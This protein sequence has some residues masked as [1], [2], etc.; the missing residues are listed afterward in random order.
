MGVNVLLFLV[1]QVLVEPWRRK[2]L[3]TG[4]EDKVMEALA[5]REA[6]PIGVITKIETEVSPSS[7]HSSPEMIAPAGQKLGNELTHEPIIAIVEEANLVASPT[8]GEELTTKDVSRPRSV[9]EYATEALRDRF[10]NRQITMRRLDITIV[11]FKS[12]AIGM[13]AVGLALLLLLRRP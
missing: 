5:E 7:S 12:A 6:V 8:A 9:V 10:S 4:F 13:A 3:V 11:A 1:F 2:R